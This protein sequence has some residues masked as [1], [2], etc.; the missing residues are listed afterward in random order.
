MRALIVVVLIGLGLA[1]CGGSSSPTAP[2]ANV[3]YSQVDLLLGSGAEAANGRVVTVHYTGWLYEAAATGNKGAQ[4][5]SSVGRSPFAFQVGAGSVIR[6]WDQ[7]VPGMRVGGQ[8]RLVIPPSLGYGSS[9]SG[10][11]P[12]NATLIFEIELLTVQ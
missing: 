5:D 9:G 1:G 6:G 10:P 2:S 11:I 3:P 4:F 8:R 7:G 12:G